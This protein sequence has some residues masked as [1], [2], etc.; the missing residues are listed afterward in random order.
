MS[1][2]LSP[3][4]VGSFVL[5]ALFL[6]LGMLLFFGSTSLFTKTQTY[7][8]Y[9]EDSVKGLSSGAFVRFKGVPIGEVRKILISYNQETGSSRVPVLIEVESEQL[10]QLAKLRGVPVDQVMKH[11][12]GNGLRGQLQM[13]SFITGMLSIDLNYFPNVGAPQYFQKSG[14]YE[15]IPT[16]KSPFADLGNGANELLNKLA[17]IDYISLTKAVGRLANSSSQALENIDFESLSKALTVFMDASGKFL[18]EGNEHGL[19][20]GVAGLT[21]NLSRMTEPDG[22]ITATI[23]SL[24]RTSDQF[25]DL[26]RELTSVARGDN[27]LGERLHSLVGNLADA[28]GAVARLADYL[29]RNPNALLT[30]KGDE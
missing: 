28:S 22:E 16:I 25:S 13:E 8:L 2:R 12:I 15:E 7:I 10:R 24:R 23:K 27:L 21:A 17:E 6:A 3:F 4:K 29:E 11:E 1:V 26:S 18:A 9:F 19:G 30:G 5:G 20:K 14:N